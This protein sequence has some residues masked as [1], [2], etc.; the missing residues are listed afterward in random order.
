MDLEAVSHFS[1]S[2]YPKQKQRE[3]ERE[4]ERET[5]IETVFIVIIWKH[6]EGVTKLTVSDKKQAIRGW[7]FA[8]LIVYSW[9]LGWMPCVS[10]PCLAMNKARIYKHPPFL[11]FLEFT[12][13]L[14]Q[15]TAE[16]CI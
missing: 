14:K 9:R 3:R 7:N 5:D 2:R 15:R 11:V 4:R 10:H 12:Q 6:I 1:F 13:C 8:Y 16:T